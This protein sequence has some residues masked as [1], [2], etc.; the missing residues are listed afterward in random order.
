MGSLILLTKNTPNKDIELIP[1]ANNPETGFLKGNILGLNNTP[2][3]SFPKS[4]LHSRFVPSENC[5]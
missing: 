1:N 3:R 5:L 4:S 2:K